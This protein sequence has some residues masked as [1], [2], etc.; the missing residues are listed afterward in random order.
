MQSASSSSRNGDP[1]Y[2]PP[3]RL[4]GHERRE[5]PIRV[6]HVG[7]GHRGNASSPRKL[8]PP[9][10]EGVTGRDR[11][12]T[13]T[14]MSAQ[15]TRVG[16]DLVRRDSGQG[17]HL[18]FCAEAKVLHQP[19]DSSSLAHR[20]KTRHQPLTTLNRGSLFEETRF[21]CIASA[22]R[23]FFGSFAT[24]SSEGIRSSAR[25]LPN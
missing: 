3:R 13:A 17:E 8:P 7:V 1:I 19:R 24:S 4:S 6:K 15:D 23:C 22:A 20:F 11:R 2:G 25:Y 10:Y 14:V 18:G 16:K 12:E 9:N 5:S 21:A